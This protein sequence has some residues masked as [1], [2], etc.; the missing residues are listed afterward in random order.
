MS[1]GYG[2]IQPPP[3]PYGSA[4]RFRVRVHTYMSSNCLG[5]LEPTTSAQRSNSG[6]NSHEILSKGGFVLME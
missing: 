4:P 6:R 2:P 1:I 5:P 3:R